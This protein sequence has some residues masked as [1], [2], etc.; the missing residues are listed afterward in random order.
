MNQ[1]AKVNHH[2]HLQNIPLKD[3]S[4]EVIKSPIHPN[5]HP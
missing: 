1:V 4:A 5:V 2:R 3:R